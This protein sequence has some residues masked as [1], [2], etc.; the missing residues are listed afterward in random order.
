VAINTPSDALRYVRLRTSLSLWFVWHNSRL[1]EIVS[2]KQAA[3]L[4]NFGIPPDVRPDGLTSGYV[5][6]LSTRDYQRCRFA[7]PVVRSARG[8]FTV[9]RWAFSY[10]GPRNRVELVRETVGRDGR[11]TCTV[12]ISKP[13]PRLSSGRFWNV[14]F[15]E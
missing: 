1:L 5:G 8:G 4:L 10:L 15:F 13:P 12:L 11:Y 9:T 2:I 14:P 7:P 3:R 6:V